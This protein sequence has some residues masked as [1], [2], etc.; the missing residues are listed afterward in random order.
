[1]LPLRKYNVFCVLNNSAL[2][3]NLFDRDS[4]NQSS[5]MNRKSHLPSNILKKLNHMHPETG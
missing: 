5:I 1:M 2:L 4:T 3:T